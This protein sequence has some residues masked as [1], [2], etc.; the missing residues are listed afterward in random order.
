MGWP[1]DITLR[2]R[3]LW[4]RLYARARQYFATTGDSSVP[5]KTG[6]WGTAS[7]VAGIGIGIGFLL[8]FGGLQ[9]FGNRIVIGCALILTTVIWIILRRSDPAYRPFRLFAYV[10]GLAAVVCSSYAFPNT[11]LALVALIWPLA[12]RAEIAI[13]PTSIPWLPTIGLLVLAAFTLIYA[14]VHH[15]SRHGSDV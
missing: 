12:P 2:N 1:G 14:L 9:L 5:S 8:V 11:W 15:R 10:V 6:S 13:V 4:Q 3:P 7:A